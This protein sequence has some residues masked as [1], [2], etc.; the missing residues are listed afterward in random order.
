MHHKHQDGKKVGPKSKERTY[1]KKDEKL[2][3]EIESKKPKNMDSRKRHER[4]RMKK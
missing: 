4:S 1:E 2:E 3:K